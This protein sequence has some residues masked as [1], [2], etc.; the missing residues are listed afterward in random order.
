MSSQGRSNKRW[1]VLVP[2]FVLALWL[3][4]FGD[5]TPVQAVGQPV[6]LASKQVSLESRVLPSLQQDA[7]TASQPTTAFTL[8][9]L[10]PRSML[11]PTEGRQAKSSRDLFSDRSWTPVA[12]PAVPVAAPAPMAPAVP[13][14]YIGK[15]LE[16]AIWQVFLARADQT[17]VVSAGSTIDGLYRIDAVA[18]PTLSLTYLPLGQAQSMSIGEA[19]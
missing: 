7:A 11:I 1:W 19:K 16:G 2:M 17:F 3:A 9:Q 8:I 4:L 14:T 10:I 12:S 13:F 15:R 6:A 18:P 5:K